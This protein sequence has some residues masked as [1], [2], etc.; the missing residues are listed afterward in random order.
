MLY[1]HGVLTLESYR[2]LRKSYSAG[3]VNERLPNS[4]SSM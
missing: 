1:V 4:A 2:L 3:A